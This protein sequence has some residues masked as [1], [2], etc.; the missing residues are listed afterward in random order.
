[1]TVGDVL[2]VHRQALA[3][4]LQLRVVQLLDS[5]QDLGFGVGTFQGETEVVQQ[6]GEINLEIEKRQRPHTTVQTPFLAAVVKGTRFTVKVGKTNA[7]V[8]VNRGL[9]QVTSF[10]SG[11]RSDLGAGQR[12]SVDLSGMSVAGVYAHAVRLFRT[13]KPVVAAVQ[14]PAIGGG[15]VADSEDEV[16]DRSAGPCELFPTLAAH[17]PPWPTS[18]CCAPCSINSIVCSPWFFHGG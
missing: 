3:V 8:S 5:C 9:V 15:L 1:M 17:T 12:A 6:V 2:P 4:V 16:H 11:E 14:G 13:G 7:A 10:R 18:R